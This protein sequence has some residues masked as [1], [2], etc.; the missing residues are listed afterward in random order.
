TPTQTLNARAYLLRN[1]E[2]H[3]GWRGADPFASVVPVRPPGTYF[4]VTIERQPRR[5]GAGLRARAGAGVS[6]PR[7]HRAFCRA[8]GAGA[9]RGGGG[10]CCSAEGGR[11]LLTRAGD[12]G[13]ALLHA[14]RRAALVI[15]AAPPDSARR[16]AIEDV[17]VGR[18]RAAEA[19][20]RLDGARAEA[21][22]L[23]A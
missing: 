14:D 6:P 4:L 20:A 8:G 10:G 13:G 19:G 17:A 21:D 3:F 9:G 16:G 15:A 2:K 5:G 11:G 22:V 18:R 1:A 23:R 12:G 7:A